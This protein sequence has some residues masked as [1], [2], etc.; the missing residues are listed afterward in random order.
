MKKNLTLT[1]LSIVIIT[2]ISGCAT[3]AER[4]VA[5]GGIDYVNLPAPATTKVPAELSTPETAPD[6]TIPTVPV[7]N[8]P[9]I[10]KNLPVVSPALVLPLARGT[11]LT[12]DLNDTSV[13]F[14]KLDSSLAINELVLQQIDGHLNRINVSYSIPD[15]TSLKVITDWVIS[16]EDSDSA[17][18]NFSADNTEVGRRFEL[19][20]E[21][22]S[23]GRSAI[24][25]VNLIDLVIASGE[26]IR[27]TI[28]PFIKRDFEATLLNGIIQHFASQQIRDDESR[29]AQIRSGMHSQLGFDANGDSAFVVD[30][31]YDVTWPKFQLV[32]RKLGF[33]VKDLDKSTGLLFVNYQGVDESWI[34]GLFG[35]S[36]E[37]PLEK[38]DYR[39]L[40]KSLASDKTSVTFMDEQSNPLTP[41][42]VSELYPAFADILSQK[43]LDI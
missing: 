6:Y 30:G 37:L 19:I 26:N 22:A 38:Q 42:K 4:R 36:D 21:P 31:N 13:I 43:E 24:L 14:D 1:A 29:I 8:T 2:S 5:S 18:Y 32:L 40:V 9:F 3:K 23:H 27:D 41:V 25:T 34:K 12:E 15:V 39:I 33:N 11:Y 10:G 16:Y 28:D 17:W 20:I 7:S 35:D